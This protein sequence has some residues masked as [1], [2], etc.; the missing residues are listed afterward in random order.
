V[1]VDPTDED[2][3]ARA[4]DAAAGLPRPNQAARQAAEPHDVNRQAERL[5]QIF[6]RAMRA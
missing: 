6:L 1:L 5:E 4:L 3:L 2:E